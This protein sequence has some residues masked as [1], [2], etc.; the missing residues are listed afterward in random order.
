MNPTL[1]NV[2]NYI[3]AQKEGR[4]NR[5]RIWIPNYRIQTRLCNRSNSVRPQ[6]KLR[7]VAETVFLFTGVDGKSSYPNIVVPVKRA[8]SAAPCPSHQS[9]EHQPCEH[10]RQSGTIHELWRVVAETGRQIHMPYTR[11]GDY[12]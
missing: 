1:V 11:C 10:G 4:V 3:Q 9:C 2:L 8:R 7:Q 6:H 5:N 12:R